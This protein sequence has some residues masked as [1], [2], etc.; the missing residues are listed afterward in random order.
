MPQLVSRP[1]PEPRLTSFDRTAQALFIHVSER[2]YV[3]RVCIL[4]Y[5]GYQPALVEFHDLS[6][7]IEHLPLG[8]SDSSLSH[9]LRARRSERVKPPMPR[10]HRQV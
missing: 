8:P 5:C 6:P 10:S 3:A 7:F 4:D 2:Q 9:R 1:R